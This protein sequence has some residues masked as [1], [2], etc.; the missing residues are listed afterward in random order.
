[1]HY[2]LVKLTRQCDVTLRY[3]DFIVGKENLPNKFTMIFITPRSISTEG[4]GKN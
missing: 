2:R 3:T 4:I 1:M